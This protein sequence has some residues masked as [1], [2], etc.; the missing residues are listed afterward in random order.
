MPAVLLKSSPARCEAT[1]VPPDAKLNAPGFTFA[2]AMSSCT[3][4]AASDGCVT[5]MKGVKPTSVMGAKSRSK[6]YGSFE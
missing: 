5:R 4:F 2:S 3:F 6:L 1:P